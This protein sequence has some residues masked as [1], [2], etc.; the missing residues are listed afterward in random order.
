MGLRRGSSQYFDFSLDGK[1]GLAYKVKAGM[2]IFI[3]ILFILFLF[4]S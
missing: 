4:G 2:R 1:Y 3:W